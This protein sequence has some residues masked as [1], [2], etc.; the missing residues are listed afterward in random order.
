LAKEVSRAAVLNAV[1][2]SA[3][4]GSGSMEFTAAAS[5]G[6]SVLGQGQGLALGQGQ[7]LPTQRR[8]VSVSS[9]P[10]RDTIDLT[11][12]LLGQV[13][14]LESGKGTGQLAV[15][16]EEEAEPESPQSPT[17][18]ESDEEAM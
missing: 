15:R 16:D 9:Q 2:S 3:G 18:S 13:A 1:P 17:Y 8:W 5:Q 10:S 6:W 4:L 11:T 14:P 12:E 7:G